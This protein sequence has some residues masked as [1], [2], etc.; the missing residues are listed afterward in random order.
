[1]PTIPSDFQINE[2]ISRSD[3]N[4]WNAC[5]RDLYVQLSR[6]AKELRWAKTPVGGI[7]AG[8]SSYAD[9][10]QCGRNP[11]TGAMTEGTATLRVFNVPGSSNPVSG[12]TYIAIGRISGTWT[13]IVEPC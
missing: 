4:N 11:V 8:T 7:A 13:V 9:C 12:N 5:I 6:T 10:I 3:A 2:G 1:M